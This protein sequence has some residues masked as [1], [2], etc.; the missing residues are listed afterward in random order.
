MDEF[1]EEKELAE[2]LGNGLYE[3]A[4]QGMFTPEDFC[5]VAFEDEGVLT[6]NSGIV[7]RFES[8]PEYQVTVV[9]SK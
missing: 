1:F 8:G 2:V 3:L 5:W 7:V 6:T 4:Y 9:R